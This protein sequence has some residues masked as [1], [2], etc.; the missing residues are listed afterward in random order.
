MKHFIFFLYLFFP[1]FVFSQSSV[2]SIY[3]SSEAQGQALSVNISCT[4]VNFGGQWTPTDFRFSQLGTNTFYGIVTGSSSNSLY[5]NVT[6]LLSQPIGYYD[7]EVF[8]YNTFQW[9]QKDSA[10]EV[11]SSSSSWD[12]DGQGNCYD[13]GSGSG[14]YSSLFQCQ[15]NCLIPSWDCDGQGNCYDPGTGSGQ[16]SSL[17]QCQSNCVIPSWDCDGQGNCYDPATGLGVYNTLIACENV[18]TNVSIEE[19][20]LNYLKFFPNPSRDLFKIT[21]K[22]ESVQNL[23]VV[24]R[25]AIGENLMIENLQQFIGEYTKQ[26]NLK[27][28]A[29]GIYF[30]DIETNKGAINKKLIL[31]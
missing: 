7:L 9:L 14:Q 11:L 8:D 1:F 21:F 15:T 24:V 10:F 17:F 18:C 12:C 16:Y 22:C 25:N 29:K 28:K 19:L 27:D 26:I 4:N 5:G 23:R 2:D 30:L 6:I 3:P 13:P 20:G 31:K